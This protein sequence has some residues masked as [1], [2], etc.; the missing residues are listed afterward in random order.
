MNNNINQVINLMVNANHLVFLTGAGISSESN[1]P[2][3]RGSDGY[4]TKGSANY[5]PMELATF[6]MFQ[7]DPAL[8]WEWYHY[9]RGVCNKASPNPGH[10]AIAKLEKLLVNSNSEQKFNLIT[11]NVDGLHLRAGSS[12][13]NTYQVHGNVNF[14]R[15]MVGCTDNIY[16]ISEKD[17]I[18]ACPDCGKYARPHVLWFDEMY[19]EVHFKFESSSLLANRVDLLFIIGT[20]LQTNLPY[21]IVMRS[22][23]RKVP[24]IDI[25]PTPIGLRE[26][27]V[28]QFKEKSG[29]ILPKIVEQFEK[30]L[31]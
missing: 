4:W 29:E 28:I 10:Y 31:V 5:S 13:N 17:L 21:R 11:Q 6:S 16:K 18:P 1:I 19:N 20:T 27:G 9:R 7:R 22:F 25:N 14:M 3:F 15:C 2:T 12:P 8:V 23:Y 30:E 24:M 26:H